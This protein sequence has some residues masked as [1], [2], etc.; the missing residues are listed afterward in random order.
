MSGYSGFFKVLA[1]RNERDTQDFCLF[2]KV[3]LKER[4]LH[5][6][7]LQTGGSFYWLQK[8]FSGPVPFM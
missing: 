3:A 6:E 2:V 7:V 4:G 5:M 8:L 1:S